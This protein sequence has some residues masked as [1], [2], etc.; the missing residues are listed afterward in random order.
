MFFKSQVER[1]FLMTG[2][3]LNCGRLEGV[4]KAEYS[5]EISSEVERVV[6]LSLYSTLPYFFVGLTDSG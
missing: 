2:T 6:E 1:E 3:L 4:E 5:H